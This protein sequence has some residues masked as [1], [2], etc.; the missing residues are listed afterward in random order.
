MPKLLFL[1]Q[2]YNKSD[3]VLDVCEKR[4]SLKLWNKENVSSNTNTT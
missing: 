4:K 3:I 1:R 2:S